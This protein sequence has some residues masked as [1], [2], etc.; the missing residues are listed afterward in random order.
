M[1]NPRWYQ[2]PVFDLDGLPQGKWPQ[3]CP[4]KRK[5]LKDSTE[6]PAKPSV[7]TAHKADFY[8]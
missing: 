5:P 6:A 7:T 1:T 8:Y 3:A 2:L 4:S